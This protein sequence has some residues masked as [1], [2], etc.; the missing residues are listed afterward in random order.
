MEALGAVADRAVAVSAL[1][2]DGLATLRARIVAA[3]AGGEDTR[4]TP[5]ISNVRHLALVDE[6]R[7]AV[8]R[9]GEA[10]ARGATEEVVLAD[11]AVARE[12]LEQVTGRRAPEDL[13]RHVFARFCVGK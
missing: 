11:L 2:G 6:A 7:G 13:L 4:D 1:T 3:L 10:L 5:A 12:A 8:G 9:A